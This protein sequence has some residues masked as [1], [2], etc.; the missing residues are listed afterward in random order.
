LIFPETFG[1]AAMTQTDV[2]QAFK[3]RLVLYGLDDRARRII[4]ETWPAMAPNLERAIEENLVASE[5]LPH[6][7]KI[8]AANRELIKEVELAHFQTLLEG[9]LDQRYVEACRRTAEQEAAIGLDARMRSC[10]GSSVLKAAIDA[11][12]RKYRLSS[13]K[14]AERCKIISQVIFFD[15][16]TAMTLHL[17]ALEQATLTRRLNIDDAIANFAGAIGGV[18]EAIKEA[19]V[20][21][22][23]ACSTLT[24]IAGDTVNGM[25]SASSASAETTQRMAVTA[26]ATEELSGSIQEIGQ[27]VTR[28]ANMAQSAVGDTERTQEAIGS[29][30]DAAER[31]GSVIGV[32]SK[33]ATQTNLLALNATIEAARAGEAGRGFAVVAA[34]VKTLANQ[35]SL[36]T[37]DI[38]RQVAAIQEG[39]KHSVDEISSIARVISELSTASV[40]IAAAMEQQ[41]TTTRDIAESTQIAA[42][43]TARASSEIDSVQQSMTRGAAAIDHITTWTARLSARAND[44]DTKVATFFS[45]VR[46]A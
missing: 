30:H 7:G 31:I 28:G 35:T 40:N 2:L 37:D 25:A 38:S 29:L 3:A 27:Q 26:T 33:I 22:T 11:L 45:C 42:N 39:T 36:A 32:I 16:A 5:N 17:Q 21:L 44:L 15:I 43:R 1:F 9:K 4:A 41:K 6:V 12:A 14:S 13:T 34:E 18:V 10:F 24:Q 19:S 23:T 20:S 46:A 8:I